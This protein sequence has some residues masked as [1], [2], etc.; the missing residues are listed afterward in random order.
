MIEIE[1]GKSYRTDAFAALLLVD[2]R[3]LLQKM[4]WPLSER[5]RVPR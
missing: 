3:I 2:Q 4:K 1:R 5:D